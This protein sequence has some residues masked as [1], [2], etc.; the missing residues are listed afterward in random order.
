MEPK[1]YINIYKGKSIKIKVCFKIGF[2][3]VGKYCIP[4]VADDPK[5]LGAH[6]AVKLIQQLKTDSIMAFLGLPFIADPSIAKQL[7]DNIP[8][9]TP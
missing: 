1:A 4:N 3:V 7:A 8:T 9:Q 5:R 2:N 6:F